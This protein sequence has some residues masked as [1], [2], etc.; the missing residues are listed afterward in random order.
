MT[1]IATIL[2]PTLG[3]P[4]LIKYVLNSLRSQSCNDFE[5]LLVLGFNDDETIKIAEKYAKFFDI[6]ILL[7]KRKGLVEAYNE[8]IHNAHGEVLIFLDDDAIPLRDFVAE[9]LLMYERTGIFLE[10]LAKSSQR[11]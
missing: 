7:Q 2:I 10:F 11:T 4:R 3:R 5:V 9:H 1:K 6:R 8:G